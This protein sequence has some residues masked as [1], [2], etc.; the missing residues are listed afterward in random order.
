MAA[1]PDDQLF[2]LLSRN[3][4]R[5]LGAFGE[6]LSPVM[7][8]D[9]DLYDVG[10]G[11]EGGFVV[12]TWIE[13]AD[14]PQAEGKY[15]AL[16]VDLQGRVHPTHTS[17]KIQPLLPGDITFRTVVGETDTT[18]GYRPSTRTTFAF[19]APVKNHLWQ[20]DERGWL[21]SCPN[22]GG[23]RGVV[24][25]S[26]DGAQHWHTTRYQLD[27]SQEPSRRWTL[28][29]RVAGG[30]I[31]MLGYF[32]DL[33]TGFATAPWS[34]Q[35]TLN[36]SVMPLNERLN[37]YAADLLPDGRL[38]FGTNRPGLQVADSREGRTF[39]FHPGPIRPD[40]QTSGRTSATLV[41]SQGQHLHFSE[42]G[43][44]WTTIDPT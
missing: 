1:T 16:H 28:D 36:M 2:V 34:G 41:W 13:D 22:Q 32:D 27:T 24:W 20:R 15:K 38:V 14:N 8:M 25:W 19:P 21:W 29:C 11:F 3:R 44:E 30:Q 10:A 31:A 23:S 5:V 42:D 9:S 17:V 33:P 18:L 39:T 12:T 4:Y 37:P 40:T 6:P 26:K 35:K 43:R 7:L